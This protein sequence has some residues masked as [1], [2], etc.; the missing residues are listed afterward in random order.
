MGG[1]GM[2]SLGSRTKGGLL[3]Q[4]RGRVSEQLDV[5]S[6][7]GYPVKIKS[8]FEKFL[9]MKNKPVEYGYLIDKNGKVVAGAK[10]G[11]HSVG[12]AY[13][14]NQEGMTVTH[15]HPSNYGGSFSGADI[16]HLTTAKLKSIRAVAKEGT[17]KMVATSKANPMEL[18]RALAKDINRLNSQASK[19]KKSVKR[20]NMSIKQY[21]TARRKAYVDTIDSWYR[22]NASKYGYK[23]T[24]EANKDYKI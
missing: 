2:N 23:Y 1:R 11:R 14:G 8:E 24:F 4:S 13:N 16:S 18:N 19:N 20:G 22:Q 7:S 9:D 5:S 21:K 17:Y 12:I 3:K 6:M 10:G 15:N